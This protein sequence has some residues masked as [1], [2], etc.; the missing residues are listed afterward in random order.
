MPNTS[1]CSL[2]VIQTRDIVYQAMYIIVMVSV[3]PPLLAS[4]RVPLKATASPAEGE[5]ESNRQSTPANDM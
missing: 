4:S 5:K 3:S 2:D 1:Y